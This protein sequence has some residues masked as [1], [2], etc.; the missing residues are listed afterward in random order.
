M[1]VINDCKEVISFLFLY[2]ERGWEIFWL[3]PLA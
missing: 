3:R 2:L 1:G